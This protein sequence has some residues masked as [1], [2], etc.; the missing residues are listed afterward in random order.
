MKL[1]PGGPMP[2]SHTYTAAVSNRPTL[3]D[4]P[5]AGGLS[6]VLPARNEIANIV[7]AV[8]NALAVAQRVTSRYEVIVVDDGSRDGTGQAVEALAQRDYP[9]VRLVTHPVN[10]G[11][12]AALRTGF[13]EARF[14]LVFFTDSDN[15]VDV[16]ELE[17]LIPL[18]T[19]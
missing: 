6:I 13:S 4:N 18:I 19:D 7:S 16:S 17:S 14:E 2:I 10:H 3:D 8:N 15:Q 5:A 9:R 11:Y 12:G 1:P